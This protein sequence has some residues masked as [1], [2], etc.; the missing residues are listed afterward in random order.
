MKQNNAQASSSGHGV[1][2][3]FSPT[4]SQKQAI[5]KS[6]GVK[7]DSD[8]DF[9]DAYEKQKQ[10]LEEQQKLLNA[11]LEKQRQEEQKKAE[12][13]KQ[14]QEEQKKA[15]D[16]KQRQK[17]QKKNPS[18]QTGT[19]SA[20]SPAAVKQIIRLEKQKNTVQRQINRWEKSNPRILT[21][22]ITFLMLAFLCMLPF[23]IT[24]LDNDL[25][26]ICGVGVV[27]FAVCALLSPLWVILQKR[28]R[29]NQLQLLSSRLERIDEQIQSYKNL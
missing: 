4:Q 1:L 19:G 9:K 29:D 3:C 26:Q 2:L 23:G 28:Q 6:F 22:F 7:T 25:Q 24:G 20:P 14:R 21:Y 15:E 12:D 10:L 18:E 16:E 8:F 13:E 17:E 5:L 11:L 27:T